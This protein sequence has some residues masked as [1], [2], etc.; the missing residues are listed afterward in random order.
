MPDV[1]WT[2]EEMA[3]EWFGPG[4]DRAGEPLQIE[5]IASATVGQYKFV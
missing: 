5:R 3:T 2:F 4:H 1:E